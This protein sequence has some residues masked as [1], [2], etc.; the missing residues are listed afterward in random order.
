MFVVDSSLVRCTKQKTKCF[1]CI[2][3]MLLFD[4]Q[5]PETETWN[6]IERNDFFY[7][8]V[9][10]VFFLVSFGFKQV[11]VQIHGLC[12]NN[13]WYYWWSDT[14][15]QCRCVRCF[16]EIAY[17]F[18]RTSVLTMCF[19]MRHIIKRC[20]GFT[21]VFSRGNVAASYTTSQDFN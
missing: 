1:C 5:E 20:D 13:I 19:K 18:D 10:V 6:T 14:I 9:V 16:V 21:R 7:V 3:K 11:I 15:W 12:L 17:L 2:L 8:F 4:E